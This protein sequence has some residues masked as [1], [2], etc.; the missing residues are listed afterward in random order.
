MPG[1]HGVSKQ[2][3]CAIRHRARGDLLRGCPVGDG[4]AAESAARACV[5][6]GLRWPA[7]LRLNWPDVRRLRPLLPRRTALPG[8]VARPGSL[9]LATPF[10]TRSRA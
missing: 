4:A 3:V 10:V 8:A 1:K 9:A 5:P 6:R 7:W 2:R